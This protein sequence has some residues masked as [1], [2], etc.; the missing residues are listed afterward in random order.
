M[1][2]SPRHRFRVVALDEID[3]IPIP[4]G[5]NWRPVRGVLGVRAFGVASFHA[6]DVGDELIEPHTETADGRGHEELYVVIKGRARFELDGEPFDAPVGTLV[7]VQPDV[8]RHA[9]AVEAGTEVLAL[10]GEPV[11]RPSGSEF[12]WRVRAALPDVPSAQTIVDEGDPDS[13][14]VTY[15]QALIDHATHTTSDALARAIALDPRLEQEATHDG[16]T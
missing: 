1:G 7:F 10:G 15:A 2:S 13:P 16:L 11:F 4:G 12:I 9:T 6:A 3:A 14:G 5:L 8:H